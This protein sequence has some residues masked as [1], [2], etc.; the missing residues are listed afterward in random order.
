[1]SQA[2]V[3]ALLA[4]FSAAAQTTVTITNI[5]TKQPGYAIANDFL[6]LSYDIKYLAATN[7]L[8]LD[9]LA[10]RKMVTRFAPGLLR[11]SGISADKTGWQRGTRN[12]NTPA[13]TLVSSD[14]DRA[15]AFANAIGFNALFGLNFHTGTPATA[16][17]EANYIFTSG[18]STLF[19]FEIGNEPDGYGDTTASQYI[20][21]W[22]AF[23]NAVQA[24]TP[25]AV[26]VGPATMRGEIN[27][28]TKPF[29]AKLGSRIVMVTQH[30]YGI[31]MANATLASLMSPNTWQ[32]EDQDDASVQSIAFAAG[33]PWRLDET[34]A[35]GGNGTTGV[36]NVFA[37]ALW[38]TDYLFLLANRGAA[39]ANVY[40]NGTATGLYSV[41]VP[42]VSD[43]H[44]ATAR[45]IYYGMLLFKQAAQGS[46]VPLTLNA[47][48]VNMTAYGTVGTDKTLRVTVINKDQTN[49]ATVQITPPAIY[50]SAT[51]MTMTA[52][53]VTSTSGITVGGASVGSDGSWN[54]NPATPV[55]GSGGV[56]SYAVPSGSA[57]LF[58][59][60]GT[61][62]SRPLHGR[63][64]LRH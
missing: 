39:G 26:L 58:T 3:I 12:A 8:N 41:V 23:A 62:A 1:M 60:A 9:N 57:A 6:G 63:P 56:F 13:N 4:I 10:Y 5:N 53:S 47:G 25:K 49:N 44:S 2:L 32:A 20:A 51:V 28:W 59:F 15:F 14:V 45:P 36:S 33:L 40:G 22:P 37:S 18:G 30:L 54:P 52:P 19:A 38:V 42:D 55:T 27:G 48:T 61:G 16:A 34:G 35:V 50:T 29:V 46:M 17:D 24:E 7:G 11:F 43:I 64:R 21:G 31:Q